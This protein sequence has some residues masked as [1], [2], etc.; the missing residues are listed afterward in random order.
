[1][2]KN[3]T[4]AFIYMNYVKSINIIASI[5]M[6]CF[7]IYSAF[8]LHEASISFAKGAAIVFLVIVVWI[9]VLKCLPLI[10]PSLPIILE[11]TWHGNSLTEISTVSIVASSIFLSC[12]VI[13]QVL[14]FKAVRYGYLDLIR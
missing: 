12:T 4:L 10:H 6:L 14:A 5:A 1:M 9:F 2:D 8:G 3:H 7:L 11:L 13:T